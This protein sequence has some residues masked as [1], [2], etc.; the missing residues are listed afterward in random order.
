VKRQ[1]FLLWLTILLIGLSL[2]ASDSAWAQEPFGGVYP[3]RSQGAQGEPHVDVLTVRGGVT[4]VFA[5]YIDR[6]IQTAE[7]DG[8]QLLVIRLDTPGGSVE[9]MLNVVQRITAARVPVVVYVSPRG[10]I[11]ASAGTFVTMAAPIAAMAPNTT[12]GAAS[13]VGPQ[14]EEIPTTEAE[15]TKNVLAG[16]LKSLV[17][18]RG[19]KAVEWAEKAVTEAKALN[20]QEALDLGV[21]DFIAEDMDVLLDKLDGRTVTVGAN[22]VT[23]HT[24][25]ARVNSIPMTLTEEILH[26]I[27]DPTIAFILLTLGLNGLIF[28][29]ANPGSILPGVVGAIC[30]ILA[31][32]ALGVLSVNYAGLLFIILAFILF[33]IDIKAPTHGVLTVGGIV[34]FVLGALVL[35]QSPYYTVSP[36]VIIGVALATATFFAFAV[37]KAVQAQRRRATTGRE[38]LVGQVATARSTLDPEGTVFLQGERWEAVVDGG[39]RVETGERVQVVA[40]EGFKLRM[41]KVDSG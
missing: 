19:P 30:L 41:R 22:T 17:Q 16:Q 28:E 33:V 8:A 13:P 36:A 38:G 26:T 12:L 24:R 3:E 2:L 14:G 5:S 10:A 20:E 21:V 4:P 34:S 7:Q 6:G 23:L 9:I 11:A 40:L 31:F 37:G 27:T 1:R 18:H 15:K 32:Y 25:G 39:G 29:L 35:F